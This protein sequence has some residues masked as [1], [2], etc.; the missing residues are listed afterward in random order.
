[1]DLT[2]RPLRRD[3]FDRLLTLDTRAFG[4]S[5]SHDETADLRGL[6]E[7]DR[8]I[9]AV[10]GDDVVGTAG[11]WTFDLTVPGGAAV[12]TAGV[13]WVSVLPTHRR[14]GI[15]R[16]MMEY[17]LDEIA[18]RGEPLAA[19]TASEST[20]YE[21]FGYGSATQRALLSIPS[22]R[23]AMRPGFGEDDR[24]RFVDLGD[25]RRILPAL[26]DQTRARQPGTVS[27]S[28][29]VWHSLLLDLPER[30]FGASELF[31][32]VHPEGFAV[33][34]LRAD[35][36]DGL[37][38]NELILIELAAASSD[39]YGALWRY[40]LRVDLVETITFRR[41][42]VDPPLRWMVDD[43]RRLRIQALWD[44]MWVRV[45]DVPAALSARRYLTED[46]LTIDVVDAFRPGC[47]GR[48]VLEG[49]PEG[50]QCV[51]AASHDA[52]LAMDIAAL[53]SVYLGGHRPTVLARGGRIEE[54][55]P[56]A[57]RRADAFFASDPP[58]YNQSAF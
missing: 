43:P 46:R 16:A 56:G 34:R 26:Y 58:P 2:V 15:L 22:K 29:A 39:A 51:P 32:V 50:A 52:D 37:A 25:A 44:D 38:H 48:F 28:A 36:V 35:I 21:R 17:Q 11:A 19:L 33:Y 55:A 41:F 10:D 57:L 42:S 18:Q 6:I 40:L 45:V 7:I 24:V 9:A 5:Y 8:T 27:R 20:I 47:G 49:G 23:V 30:R 53:G 13:T 4:I 3:E 31:V 12:P 14:R 54:V 1:M